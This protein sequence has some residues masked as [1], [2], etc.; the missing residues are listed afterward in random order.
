MDQDK[1]QQNTLSKQLERA[2]ALQ[3]DNQV[4]EAMAIFKDIL[5]QTP[6]QPDALHGI[7]MAY[8]QKR[9]FAQAVYYLEQAVLVAPE[10]AQFHNNLGNAYKAITKIDEAL[11]H[12][13]EALRLKSSY[14]EA[15]NN[16]GTLLYRIGK[17]EEAAMHFQKAIRMDPHAI[18]THYNLA[19]TYIQLDRLLD[20]SAH[21]QEVLKIRSDHLGALHN[22]G[23]TLCAL[24]HYE[25]AKPLLTQVIQREPTNTDALFHLGVIY[26][27]SAQ[28][29]EAKTCYEKV[30]EIDPLHGNS[31]HNLATI[32]LHL[33]Q[34]D[35]ALFHYQEALRLQPFNK[36]AKHMID[37]LMGKTL[38]EGAPYEYTRAL[39]DQYAYNY[40]EHVKN[41]LKYQVPFL[42]RA[43]I[44]PFAKNLV[45]PWQ[46]LDL[47]C[48]TG[49]CAP[50]FADIAG[51]L[52]GVDVS[53]NMID[54]ARQN[55]GYYKL[56]VMDIM[57]YLERHSSEFDL[58]I[59][60]DVFVYFGNLENVFAACLRALKANGFFCF[61]IENLTAEEITAKPQYPD[62]Q[63]RKTGRYAHSVQYVHRLS[64][65]YHFTIEVQKQD[66]IRYQEDDPVIGNI[67]V[68]RKNGQ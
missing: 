43:A 53:G 17:Y 25:Q 8:A 11:I 47:G 27:A 30:L 33:N 52:Y 68:L 60:A 35:K 44:A 50:L 64:D 59:S 39:F 57:T 62:Y 66:T 51:K 63:L 13:Q 5:S 6:R 3:Q 67:Y 46:V 55:G 32:Y 65:L 2:L 9:D 40:D 15:Q 56:Y 21:F 24:K 38:S 36:T 20:A 28:A 42:L 45:S 12:Y 37:A 18:D 61:S 41:R 26:S 16:L 23:I 4:D 49:L 31:H 48:G 34:F 58:I 10:I 1:D 54:V 29:N 14:P 7:G 19:L 22:L